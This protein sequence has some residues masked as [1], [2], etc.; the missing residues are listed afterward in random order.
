M[1]KGRI[2]FA[3]GVLALLLCSCLFEQPSTG[4]SLEDLDAL[5]RE[6]LEPA[7]ASGIA[8]LNW[9]HLDELAPEYLLEYYAYQELAQPGAVPEAEVEAYLQQR[10]ALSV[11]ELRRAQWYSAAQGAYLLD[12][13]DSQPNCRVVAAR[14]E[15]DCLLLDYEYYSPTG[16]A[17]VTRRGRLELRQQGEDFLFCSCSTSIVPWVLFQQQGRQSSLT[18]RLGQVSPSYDLL[19]FSGPEG[20]RVFIR[21]EAGSDGSFQLV[22]RVCTP[23]MQA[24][25][26]VDG[27]DDGEHLRLFAAHTPDVLLPGATLP[28]IRT[29]VAQSESSTA[30]SVVAECRLTVEVPIPRG[31]AQADCLLTFSLWEDG[32]ARICWDW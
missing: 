15:G 8:A 28:K 3:A 31:P 29:M 27:R 5:S 18:F 26:R 21:L 1:K 30:A 23:A 9:N 24:G 13:P 4:I 19:L 7:A 20:Q 2:I 14:Q 16:S 12:R 32:T 17:V 22:P 11:Q 25:F 10:F 6:Y